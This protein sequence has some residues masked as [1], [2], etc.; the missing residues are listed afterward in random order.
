MRQ[1]TKPVQHTFQRLPQGRTLDAVLGQLRAALADGSVRAGE[2]L[3]A[4][5]ELAR[6]L[7]VSRS[8]LRE[9]LK[10]LELSGY[11]TVRRGYGGGTFVAEAPA[12]EFAPVP[13]PVVPTTAVSRRHLHDVRLAIEPVAARLAAERLPLPERFFY[14]DP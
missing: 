14:R 8:V 7:G 4:E 6:Q 9:A 11:L 2:Q 3:P 13:P 10:A 12:D 5:P 1:E